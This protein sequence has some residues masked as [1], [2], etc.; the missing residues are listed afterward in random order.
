MSS[1]PTPFPRYIPCYSKGFRNTSSI[2]PIGIFY[3]EQATDALIISSPVFHD[4]LKTKVRTVYKENNKVDET[5][6]P[7]ATQGRWKKQL[8]KRRRKCQRHRKSDSKI[9]LYHWNFF[10]EKI[11]SMGMTNFLRCRFSPL[12]YI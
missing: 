5:K 9:W 2:W 1:R 10:L 12:I 3:N 6:A 4:L 8:G 11:F 7:P